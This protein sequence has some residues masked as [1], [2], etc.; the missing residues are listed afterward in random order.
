MEEPLILYPDDKNQMLDLI[1][2]FLYGLSHRGAGP[3]HWLLL[4]SWFTLI[5]Q[6][7]C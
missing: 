4:F 2:T 1:V 7:L 5:R 6:Q 3:L